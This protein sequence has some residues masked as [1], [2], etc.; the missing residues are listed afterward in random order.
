MNEDKW[1][2]RYQEMLDAP[3][4][5]EFLFI[6]LEHEESYLCVAEGGLDLDERG[7]RHLLGL[8]V[9]VWEET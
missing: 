5:S 3:R 7:W 1:A 4:E 2:I 8:P 9:A 6:S